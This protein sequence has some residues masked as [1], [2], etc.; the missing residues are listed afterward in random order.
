MLHGQLGSNN[1]TVVQINNK[2]LQLR[3]LC[4]VYTKYPKVM[5]K[6]SVDG[7]LV[8]LILFMQLSTCVLGIHGS[9]HV[10]I[11]IIHPFT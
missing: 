1:Y 11:A 4:T 6:Q 9:K 7:L 8:C 5:T 10:N 3:V 2:L